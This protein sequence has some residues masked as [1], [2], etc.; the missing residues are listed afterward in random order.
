L[1][2]RRF[3]AA[4]ALAASIRVCLSMGKDKN[5]ILDCRF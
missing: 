3:S 4:P 5:Q 1:K 2:K